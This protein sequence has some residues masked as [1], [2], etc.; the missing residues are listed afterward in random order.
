MIRATLKN[1]L[2]HKLRLLLSAMAVVLG[3]MSVAG[4]LVLTDTLSRSYKAMFSTAYDSVDVSVSGTPKVDTGYYAAQTTIPASVLD[5]LRWVPGAASAVGTVSSV[6]GA[7]VVGRD[8]K[9]VTS[10]GAPR[11]GVNWTGDDP[12]VTLQAGRGPRADD[13]V[14]ING[15]L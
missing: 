9:V 1:L 2:S 7:R 11:F 4:S 3:V 6:D 8:G 10:F 13:E 12:Y 5:R 15:G 14:A